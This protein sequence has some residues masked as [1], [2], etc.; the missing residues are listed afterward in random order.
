MRKPVAERHTGIP[1]Y[2]GIVH[3]TV[4]DRFIRENRWEINVSGGVEP[5]PYA[6]MRN[7]KVKTVRRRHRSFGKDN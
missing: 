4:A 7:F 3:G 2:K 1:P 6:E 5:R